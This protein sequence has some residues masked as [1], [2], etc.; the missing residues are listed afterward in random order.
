MTTDAAATPNVP[1]CADHEFDV[2]IVGNGPAGCAHAGVCR[3][4]GQSVALIG[5]AR[6]PQRGTYELLSGSAASFLDAHGVLDAIGGHA[7]RCAG[8]VF[9]WGRSDFAERPALEVAASGWI[10]DRAWLDPLLRNT[11][12]RNVC[13]VRGEAVSI[14][15]VSKGW[16]TRVTAGGRS[17]QIRA[18]SVVLASGRSGRLAGD[19][20]LVRR[21]R[22]RMLAITSRLASPI[23][24]LG[25]RLL[26]D[27]AAQGWWYAVGDTQGALVGYVTDA[28][29]LP[30]GPDRVRAMW[31]SASRRLDWLPRTPSVGA[32]RVQPA[33]VAELVIPDPKMRATPT[34]HGA[35]LVGDAALAPDP[36]SGHGLTLALH[37]ALA[38]SRKRAALFGLV[39]ITAT[40]PRGRG[41]QALQQRRTLP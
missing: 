34:H 7:E 39:G 26:V 6:D 35:L 14:V 41:A 12:A 40:P 24:W 16:V 29:L 32:L 27:S 21:R 36:L 15:R 23:P 10:V 8:T 30:S 31:T 19:L 9:R 5:R 4:R 11:M 37:G 18:N 25:C 28:D 1:P 3:K 22:H 2:A 38:R 13:H 20:G 33:T 17:V